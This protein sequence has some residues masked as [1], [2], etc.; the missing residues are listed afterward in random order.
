MNMKFVDDSTGIRRKCKL[1]ITCSREECRFFKERKGGTYERNFGGLWDCV[2]AGGVWNQYGGS[3]F[4]GDADCECV[5]KM[6]WRDV[7]F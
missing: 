4:L 3:V 5:V 2:G 6:V 1:D 7:V